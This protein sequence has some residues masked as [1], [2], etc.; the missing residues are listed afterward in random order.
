MQTAKLVEITSISEDHSKQ[1]SN[2]QTF[3]PAS[4]RNKQYLNA[5]QRIL[6]KSGGQ[7]CYLF[8]L[9]QEISH[10]TDLNEL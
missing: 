6:R 3:H 4:V 5:E 10:A 8:F 9:H 2:V 1:M 7:K